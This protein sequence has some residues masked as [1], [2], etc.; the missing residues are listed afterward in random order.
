MFYKKG[1]KI[2]TGIS[3]YFGIPNQR[4]ELTGLTTK[5]PYIA[6]RRPI[7]DLN[8]YDEIN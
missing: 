1:R 8:R 4:K 5:R 7:K 2:I 6:L 3:G